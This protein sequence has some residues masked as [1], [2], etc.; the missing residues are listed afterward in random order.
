MMEQ[1]TCP[2]CCFCLS[3]FVFITFV[4]KLAHLNVKGSSTEALLL[5][6]SFP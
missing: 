5:S 1:F 4:I 3:C 6:F 2:P